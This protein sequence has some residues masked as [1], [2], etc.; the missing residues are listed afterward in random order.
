MRH[1]HKKT[2]RV[3][4]VWE[5]MYLTYV[6][7]TNVI[8]LVN[9][10]CN[11]LQLSVI[12]RGKTGRSPVGVQVSF[13][14]DSVSRDWL[15]GKGGRRRVSDNTDALG[16]VWSSIDLASKVTIPLRHE[17]FVILVRLSGWL[18]NVED[19]A[20][21]EQVP[22]AQ[23]GLGK[24]VDRVQVDRGDAQVAP[25][26]CDGWHQVSFDPVLQG[27]NRVLVVSVYEVSKGVCSLKW[28]GADMTPFHQLLNM[29][30][31]RGDA[32]KSFGRP[33]GAGLKWSGDPETSTSLHNTERV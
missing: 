10:G 29:K 6:L 4:G 18:H 7:K 14:P 1:V 15:E 30:V 17:F 33:S 32:H 19:N 12:G 2:E 5:H 9:A 25:G 23:A 20:S 3:R 8:R 22:W 24:P 21:R 13:L 11:C 31:D 16:G 27:F 28:P 26:F